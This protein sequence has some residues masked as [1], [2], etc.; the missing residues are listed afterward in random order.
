MGKLFRRLLSAIG[1]GLSVIFNAGIPLK[2]VIILLALAIGVTWGVTSSTM[3]R[4]VG[5]KSDYEEAMRYIEIKDIAE[6]YFID[7]VDRSSMGNSAAAAMISGLGDKWSSFMSADEYKT[8]QLSSANEYSGIGISIL[9][10]ENGG[11]QVTSVNSDSPAA[12]AGLNAGMV[13]T[14]ID[15]EDVTK[16]DADEVRTLIRSRLNTKFTIGVAGQK[17]T[18]TVDCTATYVS[19]VSYRIERTGAGYIKIDNFEA[20][21]ADAAI[22][23]FE[24]LLAQH[25]TAFVIDVR[26]NPGGLV[27]E[28]NTLLDYLLPQGELFIS[29]DKGGRET[30]YS[31]DN[32]CLMMPLCVLLNSQTYSE[33]E[34]FAAV[35]QEYQW[36][37][38]IGEATTGKTRTQETI[39]V[40]DGS[41]IRL[42]TH[43]YLTANRVDISQNG[44]VVPDTIV[45]N[46]EASETLDE[47]NDG[48]GTASYNSDAQLRT[49]LT[50]LSTG[51][52]N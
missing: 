46:T 26:D 16:L 34:I 51:F 8:F 30:V 42:S 37:T 24:D 13:I 35:L 40:S 15:G 47:N 29:R 25:V 9:K 6:K 1:R 38:L 39:E 17:E 36:A 7:S 23:A 44:G 22:N 3:L 10:Q 45:Y 5:G 43:S 11:F 31:S 32:Q 28:V 27:K 48:N 12:Q 50:L 52:T 41:A 2:F 19:P 4:N 14:S 20:G 33:A 21:S 18:I 49:A